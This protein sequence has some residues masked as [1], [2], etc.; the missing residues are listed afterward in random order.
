[1]GNLPETDLFSVDENIERAVHAFKNKVAFFIR[2]FPTERT[3]IMKYRIFFRD[4]G[5]FKRKRITAV[6]VLDL[7]I[8]V[9]LN[10]GRHGDLPVRHIIQIHILYLLICADLPD[11]VQGNKPIALLSVND[12]ILKGY[13]LLLPERNVIRARRAHADSAIRI[14]FLFHVRSLS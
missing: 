1:M 12:M 9:Q 2:P 6:N 11:P 13:L 7:I 14:K 10:A 4:K 5:R 3:A 8:P